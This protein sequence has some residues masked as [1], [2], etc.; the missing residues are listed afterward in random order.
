MPV[1]RAVEAVIFDM[2]GVLADSEPIY[3]LSVSQVLS[4]HGYSL[5]EKANND[6]KEKTLGTTVEYTWNWLKDYFNLAGDLDQW[7]ETYDK[8]VLKNLKEN[9]V[10]SP[11]L[12]D[13]LDGLTARGLRIGLASSSQ[14]NWVG[15]VLSK[16]GVEERFKVVVSGEMIKQSKPDPEIFLLAAQRLEVEP[17]RCL[18]IEDSPHGIQ[19]GK[20]AGMMVIAIL[21]PYT[22]DMDLSQ[23]DHTLS[24]LTDFDYRILKSQ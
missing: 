18:V 6:I 23:A 15:A 9:V 24:S 14:G 21:T 7:I 20:S 22:R 11:G 8:V 16:L 1:T 12:Y 10:P 5:S 13:L 17:W 4:N 19:A 2:D 3:Y